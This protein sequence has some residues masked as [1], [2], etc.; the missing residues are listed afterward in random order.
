VKVRINKEDEISEL[1]PMKKKTKNAYVAGP[2]SG[3]SKDQL[4]MF[5]IVELSLYANGF[6]SVMNPYRN[7]S[8]SGIKMADAI[9]GA[10]NA[11]RRLVLKMD[12]TKGN[13]L[14]TRP[15]RHPPQPTMHWFSR[16]K[17]E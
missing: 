17:Y 5:T 14:P 2:I 13:A 1:L 10:N 4:D 6:D 11:T 7:D 3:A 9:F 15:L 16:R 12:T 8:M